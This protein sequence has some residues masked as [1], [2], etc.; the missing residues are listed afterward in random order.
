MHSVTECPNYLDNKAQLP[1]SS[2]CQSIS[3]ALAPAPRRVVWRL[4]HGPPTTK[5]VVSHGA[6]PQEMTPSPTVTLRSPS[7]YRRTT[8]TFHL[9]ARQYRR[10]SST[11]AHFVMHSREEC[12]NYLGKE[13]QPLRSCYSHATSNTTNNT[14]TLHRHM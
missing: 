9:L 1:G 2:Y 7:P 13:V 3:T 8:P 5:P 6:P 10:V 11:P 12:P 4:Y 14:Y